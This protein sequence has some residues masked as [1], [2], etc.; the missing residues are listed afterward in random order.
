MKLILKTF[1]LELQLF[2]MQFCS[3]D[4]EEFYVL[5]TFFVEETDFESINPKMN[6]DV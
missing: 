1:C 6:F 5:K 2:S 4:I 3:M